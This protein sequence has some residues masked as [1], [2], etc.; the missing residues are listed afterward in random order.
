MKIVFT[1]MLN[2]NQNS[3]NWILKNTCIDKNNIKYEIP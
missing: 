1:A 3:M 2:E